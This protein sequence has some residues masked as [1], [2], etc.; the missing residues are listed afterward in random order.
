MRAL[1]C[2]LAEPKKL[3]NLGVIEAYRTI[4]NVRL[5]TGGFDAILYLRVKQSM[6]KEVIDELLAISNIYR[7]YHIIGKYDLEAYGDFE[8]DDVFPKQ[9]AA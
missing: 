8:N 2:G 9:S 5:L 3:E 1:M 7:V 4:E 6:V